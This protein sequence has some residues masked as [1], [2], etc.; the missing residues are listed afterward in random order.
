MCRRVVADGATVAITARVT[1]R[2]SGFAGL[3]LLLLAWPAIARGD[4]VSPYVTPWA[5]T[6]AVIEPGRVRL[7]YTVPAHVGVAVGLGGLELRAVAGAPLPPVQYYGAEV[8]VRG[9][10]VRAGALRV[11]VGASVGAAT[12][13]EVGH[14][15]GGAEV[16]VGW[17]DRRGHVAWSRRRL[18]DLDTSDVV[19]LDVLT[20]SIAI[21]YARLV[22]AIGRAAEPDHC[23]PVPDARA[24]TTC[25]DGARGHAVALGGQFR[26]GRVT[27]VVGLAAALYA[28]YPPVPLPYLTISVPLDP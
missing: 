21:S 4:D 10:L 17:H 6:G 25:A 15:L 12:L 14:W 1:T 24:T 9:P 19:D 8:A 13:D 26:G 28:D 18:R 22:A 27:A 2:L 20:A 7:E 3:V 5:P 23:R 11:T 16:Q